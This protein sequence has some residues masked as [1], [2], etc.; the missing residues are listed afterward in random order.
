MPVLHHLRRFSKL[1]P[2]FEQNLLLALR[3]MLTFVP[4]TQSHCP[5]ER[6]NSASSA[7]NAMKC[8]LAVRSVC[9]SQAPIATTKLI[10][11]KFPYFKTGL[12]YLYNIF[13]KKKLVQFKFAERFRPIW[14]GTG[15]GRLELLKNTTFQPGTD[16]SPQY[17]SKAL[18][19]C[20]SLKRTRMGRHKTRLYH[21]L[22]HLNCTWSMRRETLLN[23]N[24][25]YKSKTNLRNYRA[26]TS[27]NF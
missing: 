25:I 18:G 23:Y 9:N 6:I 15:F 24:C 8:L 11:Q 5:I 4:T 10:H 20:T 12:V 1:L 7:V 14:L 27:I 22:R 17:K 26:S 3:S 21:P 19:E 16:F 2:S 13:L